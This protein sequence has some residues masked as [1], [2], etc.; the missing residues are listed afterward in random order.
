MLKNLF[1]YGLIVVILMMAPS[2]HAGKIELTTY[3]PAPTGEYKTLS[4]TEDASF[5]TTKGSVIVGTDVLKDRSIDNTLTLR[6]VTGNAA[7]QTGGVAGSLRYS[8]D[9][10]GTGVGGL[11]Y[12][13]GSSWQGLGG[14]GG[15]PIYDSG[16]VLDTVTAGVS[17]ATTFSF[18]QT[19]SVF[20][21]R[22]MIYF[23]T[24]NTPAVIYPVFSGHGN[25]GSYSRNPYG[26]EIYKDKIVFNIWAGSTLYQTWSAVSGTWADYLT[27]YWRVLVWQ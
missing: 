10:G 6:P 27:G 16:W 20:P 4:T 21:S 12:N 18:G 15:Q 24:S 1:S 25:A 8:A 22:I 19:L 14:D 3:Y 5:A 2:A 7:Y 9:A 26:I 11:L 13:N 17:H 23:A